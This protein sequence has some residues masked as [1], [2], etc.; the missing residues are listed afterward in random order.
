[1]MKSAVRASSGSAHHSASRALL[2]S[3]SYVYMYHSKLLSA[4]SRNN[5]FMFRSIARL[6]LLQTHF[7]PGSSIKSF[8]T[9]SSVAAM[10]KTTGILSWADKS[11]GEFK[12]QSSVFRNFISSKPDAEFPAEKGRYHLYVS[13]ACP[14]GMQLDLIRYRLATN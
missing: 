8:S 14:W 7:P 6:G 4:S 12:R 11:T 13:Y 2:A 10:D 3:F 9:T 5:H 1:M